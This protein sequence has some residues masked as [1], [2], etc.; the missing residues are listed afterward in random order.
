MMHTPLVSTRCEI[1]AR[2]VLLPEVEHWNWLS[3]DITFGYAK[4][5]ALLKCVLGLCFSGEIIQS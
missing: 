5:T 4:W 2:C 1:T 3:F